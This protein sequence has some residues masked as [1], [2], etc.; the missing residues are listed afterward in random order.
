MSQVPRRKF[1]AASL[2]AQSLCLLFSPWRVSCTPPTPT[3]APRAVCCTQTP[4]KKTKQHNLASFFLHYIGWTSTSLAWEVLRKGFLYSN[5]AA[6]Q[7]PKQFHLKCPPSPNCPE[8]PPRRALSQ[9]RS[10]NRHLKLG[11][12]SVEVTHT[13]WRQKQVDL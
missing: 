11:A 5:R 1:Q 10:R 12:Q 6:A 7:S 2:Q 8:L 9:W 13:L 3:L 4:C